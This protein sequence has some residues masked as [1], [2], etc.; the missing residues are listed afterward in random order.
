M[1]QNLKWSHCYHSHP[2]HSTF[3]LK[4]SIY[5]KSEVRCKSHHVMSFTKIP[6]INSLII[7]IELS[8]NTL[9]WH[10][11]AL[12]LLFRLHLVSCYIWNIC[13]FSMEYFTLWSLSYPT[14]MCTQHTP[15]CMRARTHS[16]TYTHTVTGQMMPLK[17]KICCHEKV[18]TKPLD[19]QAEVGTPLLCFYKITTL[20]KLHSLIV[21]WKQLYWYIIHVI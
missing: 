11:K 2:P 21:F 4:W 17:F 18:F 20:Q 9:T 15:A 19:I 8:L 16:H 14:W 7:G 1:Q 6:S 5:H 12:F 13:S 10:K 3:F